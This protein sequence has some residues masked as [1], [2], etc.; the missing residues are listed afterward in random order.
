MPQ[1]NIRI[2]AGSDETKTQQ[3]FNQVASAILAGKVG[4]G[5][6]ISSERALA[7]RIGVSRNIVRNAYR[8]LEAEGLVETVST[9]GRRV[10]A[11]KKK[12]ASNPAGGVAREDSLA[13]RKQGAKG[14]T[15]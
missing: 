3:I 7:E 1:L 2:R 13:A 11:S 10:R 8:R 14:R 12:R 9:A 15:R 6:S 4:P 5:E